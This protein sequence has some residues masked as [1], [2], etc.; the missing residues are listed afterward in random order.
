MAS[1]RSTLL[2]SLTMLTSKSRSKLWLHCW[3][4]ESQYPFTHRMH[5]GLL[6]VSNSL[7]PFIALPLWMRCNQP[8]IKANGQYLIDLTFSCHSQETET[9]V[10]CTFQG[11]G[12]LNF[13]MENCKYLS[14]Q[15]LCNPIF[16][17][18]NSTPRSASALIHKTCNFPFWYHFSPKFFCEISRSWRSVLTPFCLHHFSPQNSPAKNL[19][20]KYLKVHV[21]D[22]TEVLPN[23][24]ND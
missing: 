16:A 12:V 21:C 4:L 6:W 17:L 14:I 9:E 10:G 23:F 19:W 2:H 20:T 24:S 8:C 18:W 3:R 13:N 15:R 22:T 11:P 5:I 1:L 7:C